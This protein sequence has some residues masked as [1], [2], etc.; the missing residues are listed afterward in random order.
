M[1]AFIAGGIWSMIELRINIAS[2]IVGFENAVV[3][4]QDRVGTL[5]WPELPD[6]M[7][8]TAMTLAIVLLATLLGAIISVI[9]GLAAA[10][11]TSPSRATRALARTFVV[12][13]RAI[14]ELIMAIVFIRLF[15]G[16]AVAG[17]LA[18]GLNSIGMLGKF[19][20]DA[21]E[22]HDDGP[23]RALESGGSPRSRQIFGA[24][25]PG[26]MPAI[27]AHGL[28]RFDINL[29][30]SVILG[31]IG[32][33]GLGADLS[34]ALGVGSY[35]RAIPLA[36]IILGICIAAEILS[37]FLRMKLLGRS[38]PS[39]YGFIW[40]YHKVRDRYRT[41]GVTESTVKVSDTSRL[42][43]RTTPPW[44]LGRISRV[45]A[46]GLFLALI[47]VSAWYA[48]I[49]WVR[50]FEGFA[51]IP[52]VAGQFWP[53]D[54]GDIPETLWAA[55][56]TTVQ[57]GLAATLLG[58]ILALPVGA[59]AAR[60]V[61]PNPWVA[62]IFRNLIVVTRGIPELILAIIL[63]VIMGM[64]QVAG[65]LALA[66]GAMGLLSKLVADSIEE[67]DVRV[68]QAISTGGAG[69]FQVFMAATVR[70]AAPASVAHL[71]YQLDVNIRAATLLGIVGAGGVGYYL[72]NA[73]RVLS[74]EVVTYILLMIF[75]VVL[76]L[77]F[78][79]ILMR[80]LL[81]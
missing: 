48:E 49:D 21:I 11:N 73:N 29:R 67:T 60:N 26:I 13:M 33:P 37:G 80:R 44:N 51:S 25:I 28:H 27:V 52:D 63:I 78:I 55:L 35:H 9:L 72:L 3:F 65:T 1:A 22:D 56:L 74:F 79:S 5:E 10:F 20:A 17:I 70:Q 4:F 59:M 39:R 36:L 12:V 68:Q 23:R 8:S 18:L 57:M 46:M 6:L 40:A 34:Q 62:Q 77:E 30:A 61:A 71:F 42:G 45:A 16:G 50:F 15:G 41:N 69:R 66:L 32:L 43:D 81:R 14:P 54:D 76:I 47:V 19:Y 2:L 24:T 64:G 58:A 38:E 75:V 7:E 53:P 31:W